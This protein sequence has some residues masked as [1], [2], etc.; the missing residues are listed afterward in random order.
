LI[1]DLTKL[2][3]EL[4]PRIED[5]PGDLA[6]LAM[7]VEEIMPGK[8]VVTVLRMEKEY[9]GTAIYFHN[10]DGL[11]RR[12][13]DAWIIE[14]YNSGE[15]VADIARDPRIGLSARQVW[16]IL[17]REPVDERQLKLF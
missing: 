9:R 6:Q 3:D 17:G 12:V 10:L 7:I 5:L 14:R 16:N 13:R 2:P 8:G 1:D 15:K 11:R 4:I